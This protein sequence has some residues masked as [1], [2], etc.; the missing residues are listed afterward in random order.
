[1]RKDANYVKIN[2]K[3]ITD[4]VLMPIEDSLNFFKN[5]VLSDYEHTVADRL[6]IEIK[7]RLGFLCDVGLPYLT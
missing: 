7:N 1:L 6:L 5:I 3:S 2:G 4:L